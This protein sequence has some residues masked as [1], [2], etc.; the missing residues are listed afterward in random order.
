MIVQQ[1][2]YGYDRG[3]HGL[4]AVS[5]PAI[6]GPASELAF[7]AD[8][9][10]TAPPGSDW[11]PYLRGFPHGPSLYILLRTMP[12]PGAPR[13]GMVFTHALLMR[14]DDL[15]TLGSLHRAIDLLADEPS[16]LRPIEPLHLPADAVAGPAPI[17]PG[18]A[19]VAEALVAE[20]PMPVVYVG[21]DGW[22]DLVASLWDRFPP[23]MRRSFGFRLSFGP[24]DVEGDPQIL[25]C[26]P[27]RLESRWTSHVRVRAAGGGF[28]TNA[29]RLL[30]SA[31]G[32][33]GLR[34]FAA[35]IGAEPRDART[36]VRLEH[37]AAV[38]AAADPKPGTLVE[39]VRMTGFLSPDPGSGGPA[40]AAMLSALVDGVPAMAGRDI[41]TMRQ[42]RMDAF[43][44]GGDALWR[45]VRT[46]VAAGAPAAGRDDPDTP[47]ILA[48]ATGG[49]P[50]AEWR[51]A[52]DAGLKDLARSPRALSPRLWT[53]WARDASLVGALAASVPA[54]D[55]WE[56]ELSNAVPASLPA[57]LA[58]AVVALCAGR[59]WFSLHAAVV[60]RTLSFREAVD[61][62][63][64]ID[65]RPG[66]LEPLDAILEGIAGD[67]VV[68]CSLAS[69]DPRMIRR[70]GEACAGEPNLLQDFDA[71]VG[72]WRGVLLAAL[73]ARPDAWRGLPDPGGLVPSLARLGDAVDEALWVA[74]ART[75]LANISGRDDRALTWSGVPGR[76]RDAVLQAT[77]DGWLARWREASHFEGVPEE[78]LRAAVLSRRSVDAFLDAPGSDRSAV[79][80]FDLFPELGEERFADWLERRAGDPM[81]ALAAAEAGRLAKRRGW[82]LVP[83]RVLSR[84]DTRPDLLP[85][86]R[87][88][89][90]LLPPLQR[91]WLYWWGLSLPP[92]SHDELWQVLVDVAA[93]NFP[94]ASS[95]KDVW[96]GAGGQRSTFPGGETTRARWQAAIRLIRQGGGGVSGLG[97]I[98]AMLDERPRNDELRKLSE[99]A[100]FRDGW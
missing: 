31:D 54:G 62:Q 69:P 22:D 56:R 24:Q 79:E 11:R 59:D 70:A 35:S 43:P 99:S 91:A 60:K 95:A 66:N 28:R 44:D 64:A 27:E 9:P 58:E 49:G 86:L 53:W 75:P 90:D 33:E 47:R 46:W 42:L 82:G 17:A 34:T 21:Q 15:P 81:D 2:L 40:K 77:A 61:A 94:E 65:R 13:S 96:C 26:T 71:G 23:A 85:A 92:P 18:A 51:E 7:K 48:Q 39:L 1:A 32:S 29:A 3:G 37:A 30:L 12:D 45:S 38:A 63:L 67:E 80:L 78:P 14:L 55:G 19:D 76:F 10:G 73:T 16:P 8:L 72:A 100:P 6:R 5:D 74:V 36:V 52:V 57:P 84:R 83:Q 93:D 25:V 88:S 41:L 68:A 20:A 97:L 87:E 50:I 4:L 98:R 89:Y